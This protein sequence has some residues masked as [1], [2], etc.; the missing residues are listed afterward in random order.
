MTKGTLFRVL[1]EQ[2]LDDATGDLNRPQKRV[3][4]IRPSLYRAIKRGLENDAL[5]NDTIEELFKSLK[6]GQEMED[7]GHK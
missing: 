7:N 1:L 4:E 2:V 6:I 3:R 5:P